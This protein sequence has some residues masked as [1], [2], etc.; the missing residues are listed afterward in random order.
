MKTN[1]VTYITLIL[2]VSASSFAFGQYRISGMVKSDKGK[3]IPL[4]SVLL[5]PS[6]KGAT[7]DSTG[8]FSFEGLKGKQVLSVSSIGYKL[9]KKDIS[10][11][12]SLYLDIVLKPDTR[13]LNEV[14]ISAGSFEA[15]DKAK[16]A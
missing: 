13:T 16:G 1:F 6:N 11:D 8:K 4:A 7:T 14:T 5:S 3:A 9:F 2:L 10:L 12:S 15:S